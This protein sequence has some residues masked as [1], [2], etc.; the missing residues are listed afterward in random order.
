[1]MTLADELVPD[2]LWA[3]VA[4]LLPVPPSLAVGRRVPCHPDRARFTAI[5]FMAR[6]STRS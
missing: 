1:M 4:P 5:V 3:L 2:Q 6:A